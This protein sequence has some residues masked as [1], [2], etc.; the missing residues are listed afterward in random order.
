MEFAYPIAN[1]RDI[2]SRIITILDQIY[3]YP[4]HPTFYFVFDELDKIETPLRKLDD[5]MP[6]F[7]NENIYPQAAHR[8]KESLW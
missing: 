6:E 4:M 1:I 3:R 8:G 2:E 7:S 5:G